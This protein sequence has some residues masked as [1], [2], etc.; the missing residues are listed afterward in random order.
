MERCGP[1]GTGVAQPR[2]A[3][4]AARVVRADVVGEGHLRCVL[5]GPDGGRLKGI[6]FRAMGS[7]LGNALRQRAGGAVH[8]AGK[9]RPD[10][11]AG[12]EAVQFI[13]EDAAP[14]AG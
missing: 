10:H 7:E 6:A 4:P 1:F 3:L 9:L 11:W 2:F 5:S 14:V 12:P 8:L 13:I